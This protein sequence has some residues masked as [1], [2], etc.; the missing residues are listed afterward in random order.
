[1]RATSILLALGV[2][3][4]SLPAGVEGARRFQRS[5]AGEPLAAAPSPLLTILGSI[6]ILVLGCWLCVVL[7]RHRKA[8]LTLILVWSGAAAVVAVL[9]HVNHV[10]YG[11]HCQFQPPAAMQAPSGRRCVELERRGR[12]HAAAPADPTG[13]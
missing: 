11:A 10:A 12:T 8:S 6:A 4:L 2:A 9:G 7:L 5:L 3:A 13:T 1:M